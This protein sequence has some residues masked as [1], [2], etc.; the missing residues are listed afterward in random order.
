MKTK[1][2][3]TKILIEH[4]EIYKVRKKVDANTYKKRWSKR[5]F[6]IFLGLP[7]V[8]SLLIVY[9]GGTITNVISEP[10][11]LSISIFTPIMFGLLPIIY[12]F[13]E[14]PLGDHGYDLVNQFKANVLFVILISVFTLF[15]LILFSLN[16]PVIEIYEIYWLK[17]PLKWFYLESVS[18]L[19]YFFLGVI[20]LHILMILQRFNFL[21]NEFIRMQKNKRNTQN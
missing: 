19:I 13:F 18:V 1:I 2:S 6:L 10:L 21:M 17:L 11:L 8:L 3:I 14:K 5:D 20:V 16:L 7:F 12:D 9:Y 15:L 4:F